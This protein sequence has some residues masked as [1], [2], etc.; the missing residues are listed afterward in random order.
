MEAFLLDVLPDIN[1]HSQKLDDISLLTNKRWVSIED[2]LK[3]K[4]IY[5]FK[6]ND[7]LLITTYGKVEKAKWSFYGNQSILIN[8]GDERFLF[9]YSYYD[10]NILVLKTERSEEYIVF[11]NESKFDGQFNTI[12]KIQLYLEH[13]FYENKRD[14][15]YQKIIHDRRRKFFD[16]RKKKNIVM[17]EQSTLRYNKIWTELYLLCFAILLLIIASYF[18]KLII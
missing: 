8:K 4:T 9:K 6:N 17:R 11:V 16:E 7:D 10:Q 12:D 13:K 15:R 2:N 14:Y 18:I 5:I 1:E 3:F